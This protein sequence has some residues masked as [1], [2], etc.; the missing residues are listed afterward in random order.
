M[1]DPDA[2]DLAEAL[3]REVVA[4]ARACGVQVKDGVVEKML[5]NTAKMTPYHTSMMLDFDRKRPLEVES[6]FGRPL[7]AAQQAGAPSPLLQTVYRQLAFLD[8]VNRSTR[9]LNGEP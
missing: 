7:A 1:A 6:I 3:M 8:R 2:R 4:D 5:D 9:P